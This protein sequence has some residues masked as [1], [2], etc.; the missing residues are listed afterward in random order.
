MMK[1]MTHK[2]LLAWL[3]QH[4]GTDAW[5][6]VAA[7]AGVNY[8]TVARIARGKMENPSL[9]LAEKIVAGIRQV[10]SEAGAAA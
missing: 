10:E 4:K 5:R 8:G 7:N 6:R 2:E 9:P 1:M 3:D